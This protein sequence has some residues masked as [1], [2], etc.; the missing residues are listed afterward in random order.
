MTLFRPQRG[1]LEESME[2]MVAVSDKRA[3]ANLLKVDDLVDLQIEP[4]CWDARIDWDTH[5]VRVKGDAVGFTNG[6]L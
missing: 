6:K 5:I 1:T 2:Y 3:L 4:Y